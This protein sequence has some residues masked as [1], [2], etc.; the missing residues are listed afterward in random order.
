MFSVLY[1]DDEPDLLEVGKI[2]LE[3]HGKFRVDTVTSA[4]EA[5]KLLESGTYEAIVSDYQMPVMDGIAFLKKI[6]ES[7]NAIPFIIFTGR[8]REE[9]V[10]QALNEGADFYLQKGGEAKAQFAELAH[11]IRQAVEHRRAERKIS[12]QERLRSDI[13]NFLPDATFAIDINGNVI[14]WNRA[15]EKLTGIP[16]SRIIGKGGYEYAVPFY[17]E[18]RPLLIDLVLKNDPSVRSRYPFIKREGNILFA[19]IT[20]PHFREGRDALFWFTASP[21]FDNAGTV[22]G[23]IESIRNITDRKVAKDTLQREKAFFDAVIDCIPNIFIILDGKGNIVRSNRFVEESLGRSGEAISDMNLLSFVVEEDRPAA[24]K[25][26]SDV[27]STGYGEIHLRVKGRD[28]RVKEYLM[29][30]CRM[31]VGEASYIVG[32][33]IEANGENRRE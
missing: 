10:I 13:L 3:R 20:I 1:V 29:N 22:I 6:R 28:A 4:S 8:G 17:R 18:H 25:T 23:A 31:V 11:K 15:M 14:A 21:L 24:Q 32:V 12:D 26:L 30:G 16:A 19:E 7:G 5:L 27:L 2:S 9:I 33:G